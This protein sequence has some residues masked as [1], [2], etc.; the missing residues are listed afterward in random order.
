MVITG[1]QIEYTEFDSNRLPGEFLSFAAVS[2]SSHYWRTSCAC[3]NGVIFNGSSHETLSGF[4]V[5][6]YLLESF[7]FCLC[8][9]CSELDQRIM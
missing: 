6:E 1:V 3:Q 9:L 8:L 5:L 7:L 4:H 2:A